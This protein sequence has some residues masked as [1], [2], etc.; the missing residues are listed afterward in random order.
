M[1]ITE[2][3]CYVKTL[4]NLR[5]RI[6]VDLVSNIKDYLKWTS[7]LRYMSHKIFDNDFIATRKSKTSCK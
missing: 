6:D 7:K 2:Q 5:N 1:Q 4:E 3:C